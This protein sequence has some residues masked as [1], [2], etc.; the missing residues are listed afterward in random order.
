ML[1]PIGDL[2]ESLHFFHDQVQIYPIWL[3]PFLLPSHP[4]MLRTPSG[5]DEMFIDIG[6]YGVPKCKDFDAV[7]TTRAVERFVQ[8]KKGYV[9]GSAIRVGIDGRNKNFN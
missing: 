5:K 8:E 2:K 3:C 1:V 7:K 6:V 9:H 4:G